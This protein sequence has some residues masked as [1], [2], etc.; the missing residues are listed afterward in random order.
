MVETGKNV[1]A[2]ARISR[3]VLGLAFAQV[4]LGVGNVLT[5]LSAHSQ[6]THSAVGALL[7]G[8]LI[9]LAVRAGAMKTSSQTV[10]A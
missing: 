7:W 1:P 9:F 4:F 2:L 5:G 3:N 10:G 8:S 6:L